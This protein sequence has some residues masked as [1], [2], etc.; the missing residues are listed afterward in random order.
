M[1]N[2]LPNHYESKVEQKNRTKPRNTPKHL[3]NKQHI[4]QKHM[5][6]RRSLH[7]LF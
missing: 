7:V 4:L 1:Q 3:E 2:V 5:G 6:Q